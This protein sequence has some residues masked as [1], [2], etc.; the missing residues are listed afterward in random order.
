MIKTS[1]LVTIVVA[2]LTLTRQMQNGVEVYRSDGHIVVRPNV[3]ET[4][5]FDEDL[6]E[7]F[8][9]DHAKIAIAVRGNGGVV[10]QIHTF[11]TGTGQRTLTTI[12]NTKAAV[13]AYR[14]GLPPDTRLRSVF[15]IDYDGVLAVMVL[16][17]MMSAVV[18]AAV[19]VLIATRKRR[20][21][22]I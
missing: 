5:Y 10:L 21:I 2:Q 22:Q 14:A 1:I 18:L 13:T 11:D 3:G 9:V 19:A 8:W 16:A 20:R 12:A 17:I 6:A 4:S 15:W 7:W